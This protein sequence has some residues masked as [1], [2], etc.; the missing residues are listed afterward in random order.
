MSTASPSSAKL[1]IS[2]AIPLLSLFALALCGN[3]LL[4]FWHYILVPCS[5]VKPEIKKNLP[6][7]SPLYD[8]EC[9]DLTWDWDQWQAYVDMAITFAA[10]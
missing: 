9:T 7:F 5:R 4:T 2:G 6:F 10:P 8:L 3:C 1:K